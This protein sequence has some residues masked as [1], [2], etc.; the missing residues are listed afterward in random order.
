MCNPPTWSDTPERSLVLP[1][2]VLI[3]NGFGN[4][5]PMGIETGKEKLTGIFV[6]CDQFNFTIVLLIINEKYVSR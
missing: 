1:L 5:S 6:C 3:L 4:L 2:I